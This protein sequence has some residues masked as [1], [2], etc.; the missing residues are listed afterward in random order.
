VPRV[1]H[2]GFFAKLEDEMTTWVP[3]QTKRSPNR[4]DAL[5]WG[6]LELMKL[7]PVSGAMGAGAQVAPMAL[8]ELLGVKA[9]A[10]W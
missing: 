2:V 4:I 10:R 9:Q 8:S 7:A 3:G 6:V 5:V 1:H